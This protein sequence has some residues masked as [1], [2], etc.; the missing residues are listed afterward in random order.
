MPKRSSRRYV[1]LYWFW[2]RA[3]RVLAANTNFCRAFRVSADEI[4]GRSVFELGNRDW[5]IPRF[6]QLLEELLPNGSPY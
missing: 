4:L 3:Q 6:R 1:S 5:D 2:T